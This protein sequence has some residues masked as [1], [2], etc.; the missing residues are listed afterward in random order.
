MQAVAALAVACTLLLHGAGDSPA[1]TP[2]AAGIGAIARDYVGLALALGRHDP[3]YVDSYYGPPAWKAQADSAKWP[4]P[5]I[6][7]RAQA[8]IDALQPLR[9][10]DGDSMNV[11]RHEH[12]LAQLRSLEARAEMLDGRR[13]SFD[14]ESQALYN[15]VSP[16]YEAQYFETALATL[17][18]LLPG[19]GPLAERYDAFRSRLIVPAA[20]IDT[21]MRAAIAECRARTLKHIPLPPNERY[22]VEYVKGKSWS[23]YNW[24]Q[25]D[26]HSL[27]Q[28]NVDQPLYVDGIVG[29]A[30][31]EGYPGHHVN[32]VLY[33]WELVNQRGWVEFSVLPLFSPQCLI[34]EGSGNF[35]LE[36]L[37]TPAERLAWEKRV[38][39]PLAGIDTALARRHEAVRHAM[40]RL[41]YASN[42][43]GRRFLQGEADSA[44]TVAW[45]GR[46]TLRTP[47]R[48]ARQIKFFRQ[49]RS[50]IINYNFGEDLVQGFVESRGGTPERRWRAFRDLIATPRTP[51][52]IRPKS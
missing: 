35:G 48:A 52:G 27:I 9:P 47:E 49:Y 25:G 43:A 41:T 28:V 51:S 3:D 4:L 8:L 1:A 40:R 42:E 23:A 39:Y 32:A 12:L 29:L 5:E 34:A 7:Q 20:R 15:A 16:R 10:A 46:Y 38:L 21:V 24:Y 2:R 22:T 14:E 17:D 11:L 37:F 26:Y 30:G 6:R 19:K 50:Y 13:L 44:A 31:H 36:V 18:S 33:E 45:L